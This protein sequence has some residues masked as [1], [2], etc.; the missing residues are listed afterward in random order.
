[1]QGGGRAVEVIVEVGSRKGIQEVI[2]SMWW[3]TIDGAMKET[4]Y[5]RVYLVIRHWGRLILSTI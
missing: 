2:P 1:M 5:L 3:F 4:K